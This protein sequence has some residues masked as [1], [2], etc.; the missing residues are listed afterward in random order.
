MTYPPAR[1]GKLCANQ[2]MHKEEENEV[3]IKLGMH[4]SGQLQR[5]DYPVPPCISRNN[6][7][8]HEY[9]KQPGANSVNLDEELAGVQLC[10]TACFSNLYNI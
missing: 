5:D 9:Q 10:F 7:D 3:S 4:I 6:E 1:Q 8:D 2:G